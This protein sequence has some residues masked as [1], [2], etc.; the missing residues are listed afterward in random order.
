MILYKCEK[1]G[2]VGE[3]P[4]ELAGYLWDYEMHD[5]CPVCWENDAIDNPVDIIKIVFE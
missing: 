4:K 2:W 1:C 3:E 5:A